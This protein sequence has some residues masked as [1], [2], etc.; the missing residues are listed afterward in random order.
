MRTKIFKFKNLTF[1]LLIIFFTVHFKFFENTYI[2]LKSDYDQRLTQNYGYCEKNSYGFIKYIEKKYQL[3]KNINIFNDESYPRSDVFIYK[4]KKEFLKNQ[5][6][7]INYNEKDSSIDMEEYN[8][9]EKFK[10]CYYLE[11]K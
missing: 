6:I 7:L 4:P 9:I 11:L 3:K 8:V 1:L 2:I 5:I 10:N